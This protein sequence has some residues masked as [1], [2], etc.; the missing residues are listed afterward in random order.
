[1]ERHRLA[2]AGP[3]RGHTATLLRDGRVLV[4]GGGGARDSRVST[5]PAELYDP[6]TGVWS[7]TAPARVHSG[8]TA[9][10]LPS[11]KVLV[12]GEAA[13]V[14]DP[15]TGAWIATDAPA[16]PRSGGPHRHPAAAGRGAG[17]GAGEASAGAE[18]Y[19]PDR[20]T[21]SRAAPLPEGRH[22]G[23]TRRR[24]CPRARCWWVEDWGASGPVA[25]AV[26]HMRA[27]GTWTPTGRVSQHRY[28]HTATLL[29]DGKV[30]V[31]G[32]SSRDETASTEL[33]D[34]AT[35]T[36]SAAAPMSAARDSH[37]ATL[38]PDGRVLVVG[39]VGK[40]PDPE[41]P[42]LGHLRALHRRAV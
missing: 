22:G 31:A 34:P 26:V 25:G 13:E 23:P 20:G 27:T 19:E 30:L 42:L 28:N 16:Q 38:L 7:D 32:G 39:G 29:P 35:G 24:C 21:W 9:T 14:Y 36:W 2:V 12:V 15:V 11:G 3:L 1:M 8:H 5:E 10:L 4:V 37:T 6:A 17:V 33:Y 18:F 41:L 40:V